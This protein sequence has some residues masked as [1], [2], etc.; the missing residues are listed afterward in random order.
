MNTCSRSS[1]THLVHGVG[2]TASVPVWTNK[3]MLMSVATLK[4]RHSDGVHAFIFDGPIL[5]VT[6]AFV[7]DAHVTVFVCGTTNFC[8]AEP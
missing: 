3:M 6:V 5:V 2:W 8:F 4:T 7:S 1:I